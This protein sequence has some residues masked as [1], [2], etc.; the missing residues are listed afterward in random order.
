MAQAIGLGAVRFGDLSNDRIKDIEFDWDQ[1]MDF[2]G[3]TAPYVQY[4]HARICSILRKASPPEAEKIGELSGL[5][6][7]EEE[8]TLLMLL[9][10]LPERVVQAAQAYR[11]SLIARYLL[12]VAREFNRFYHNC[13]VLDSEPA[14]RAA[15]LLLIDGTRQVLA[16]GLGL[17]GI[18]APEEM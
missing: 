16:N 6:Q 13:P 2:A 9:G 14:L 17:L 10:L 15:R 1:V 7:Q 8:A 5:L 11:P 18:E 4:S 12:E 3:E